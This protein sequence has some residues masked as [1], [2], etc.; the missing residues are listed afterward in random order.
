MLKKIDENYLN[1]SKLND[2][3]ILKDCFHLNEIAKISESIRIKNY[4]QN[5][6]N[7]LKVEILRR[8]FIDLFP[9]INEYEENWK[10]LSS[11]HIE[12]TLIN[13]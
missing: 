9:K 3:D 12:K 1:S 13:Q 5:Y 7:D 2:L 10:K 11:R 4:F 6:Y 8:D